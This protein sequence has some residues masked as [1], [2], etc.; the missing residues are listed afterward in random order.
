M[1]T[2]ISTSCLSNLVSCWQ[3]GIALDEATIHE[4]EIEKRR[5]EAIGNPTE[6][7]RRNL[8]HVTNLLPSQNSNP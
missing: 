3:E 7:E 2:T 1:I 8:Q 6:Q 4:L 5:L